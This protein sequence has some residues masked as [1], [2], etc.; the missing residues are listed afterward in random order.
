MM[1]YLGLIEKYKGVVEQMPERERAQVE[2]EI[3]D[4]TPR[5]VRRTCY[6]REFLSKHLGGTQQRVQ[7]REALFNAGDAATPLWKRIDDLSMTPST[8]LRLIREAV[9]RY[10]TKGET[11]AQAIEALLEEHDSLPI[12]RTADGRVFRR[13][14]P[15]QIRATTAPPPKKKK[16]GKD[17][18]EKDILNGIRALVSKYLERKLENVD[19]I[20][21]E[22]LL[23]GF[24]SEMNGLL[25]EFKNKIR[26]VQIRSQEEA[27]VTREISRREMTKACAILQVKPPKKDAMPDLARAKKNKRQFARNM[28]PDMRDGS[29]VMAER[30]DEI[31]KAYNVLEEYVAKYGS[32]P[33]R[34]KKE[35]E[36]VPEEKTEPRENV[37]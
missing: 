31:I 22:I 35:T 20:T 19:P 34:N 36:T 1:D 9:E 26:T 10:K 33:E 16:K 14:N 23:R 28:H 24:T 11:L 15:S 6:R 7:I 13:R 5:S 17:E 25:Y 18:S 12:A 37:L 3:W 4:A 30:F 32:H 2:R 8:A 21:V 29:D 27:A